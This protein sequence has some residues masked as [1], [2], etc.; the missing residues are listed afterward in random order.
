M[1]SKY[2]LTVDWCNK[3]H[4][5]VFCSK[6]GQ[7]FSKDGEPHTPEEIFEILDMFEM[8]L[9][10]KSELLTIEELKE[11][12]QYY[13]LAEYSGIYGYATKKIDSVSGDENYQA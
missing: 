3:G 5:G 2:F 4:R 1:E 7:A 10:P 11:Y 12:N 6:N 9:S 8:I 13:P